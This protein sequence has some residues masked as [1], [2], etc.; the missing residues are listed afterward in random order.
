V[1]KQISPEEL[2]QLYTE[3]N[4]A[5]PA[6][7]QHPASSK[8]P[9]ETTTP[10]E[11]PKS[12]SASPDMTGTITFSLEP[13]DTFDRIQTLT[14]PLLEI[15]LDETPFATY[16]PPLRLS[17]GA[18]MKQPINVEELLAE[19]DKVFGPPSASPRPSIEDSLLTCFLTSTT[20]PPASSTTEETIKTESEDAKEDYDDDW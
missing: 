20:P 1:N 19:Y 7:E 11:R 14:P 17:L 6:E 9:I 8:S 13:K 4:A 15:T 18:S 3:I 12:G 16:V 10:I 5:I 2:Q